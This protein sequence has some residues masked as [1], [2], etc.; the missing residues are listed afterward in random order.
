MTPEKCAETWKEICFI[1]SKSVSQN[2]I[3]KD[4]EGPCGKGSRNS[5]L[6]RI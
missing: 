5:W 1:L 3:E 6:E 4:F 2:M